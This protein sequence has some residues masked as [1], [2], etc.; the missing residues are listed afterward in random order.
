MARNWRGIGLA[1][2]LSPDLLNRIEA[3]YSRADVDYCLEGILAEWLK[4][5]Y[6]TTRFGLPSW[7]QLVAAVAHPAG[8]SDRALAE[9]IAERHNGK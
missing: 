5:T 7:K 4:R 1:L 6:D 8:G 2:R 9:Q 3:D